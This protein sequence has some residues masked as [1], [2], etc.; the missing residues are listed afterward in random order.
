MEPT[1]APRWEALAELSGLI[2]ASTGT[3][4][5]RLAAA[6]DPALAIVQIGTFRGKSACYLAE[7]AR[8]GRGAH[9]YA[10][11][12][13]DLAGNDDGKHGYAAAE[14]MAD[15]L[16]QIMAMDLGAWIT[17]IRGFSVSVARTWSG[18]PV[19]LL[20]IDGSHRYEDV[21][22][23]YAAWLPHLT[24]DAVVVFDDYG[25]KP[26]PGVT[27]FVDELEG[28]WDLSTPPLAILS[29]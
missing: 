18:H 4:L 12:P 19:G 20:F 29:S 8:C 16:R 22:D 25:T 11:D 6:V 26:N 5:A 28:T 9:T 21:R 3:V 17:A 10:I 13:W 23:D 7:G 24:Q 1:E 15:C 27:R 14:T 2:T